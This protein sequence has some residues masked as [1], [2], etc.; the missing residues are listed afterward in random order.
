MATMART[1]QRTDARLIAA[2][3]VSRSG[4][5]NMACRPGAVCEM[6]LLAEANNRG[7]LTILQTAS[8]LSRHTMSLTGWWVH[9]LN[10][11]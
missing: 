4:G 2:C 9:R 8:C 10:H 5:I 3:Y 7:V 1:A 11:S 6:L